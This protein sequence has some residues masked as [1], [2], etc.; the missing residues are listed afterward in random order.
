VGMWACDG[1]R[2]ISEVV[3]VCVCVWEVEWSWNGGCGAVEC[4][5]KCS[6]L[7]DC[8]YVAVMC[9]YVSE[10]KKKK[11]QGYCVWGDGGACV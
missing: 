7:R 1:A 10:W 6:G 11:V 2:L 3:S 5:G 9:V 8:W 4:G